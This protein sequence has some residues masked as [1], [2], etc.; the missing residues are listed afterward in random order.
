MTTAI[1]PKFDVYSDTPPGRDPD[2]HSPTLR[3]YHRELWS[4]RLPDGSAFDLSVGYPGMYL[5]H[6]SA[7]GEF[8]LSS[9]SIGHTYRKLKSMK[10][11]IDQMPEEELDRFYSICSTVGG[12]IVLLTF[13]A[14]ASLIAI[15]SIVDVQ[16]AARMAVHAAM[17]Q[18]VPSPQRSD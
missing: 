3:R 4:K 17:R 8:S 9:D 5:H 14:N 13:A 10:L 1:D 15:S 16:R 6:S 2:S 18:S 11:I 12:Y 7:L